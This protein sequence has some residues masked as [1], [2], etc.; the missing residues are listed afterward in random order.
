MN[1]LGKL[2][3]RN[4]Q[5]DDSILDLGSGIMQAT[6]ELNAKHI[7]GVDIF[8]N[9]LN[10]IKHKFLT[11]KLN[12]NETDR[13]MDDSYDIV[14]CLDVIE[15]LEKQLALHIISECKRICRKR[16]IIYTPHKFDDNKKAVPNSWGLGENPLQEHLCHIYLKDLESEG[17]SVSNPV[18]EGYLGVYIKNGN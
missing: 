1:W 14:L 3:Q 17:Y 8:D 7:L 9:Y 6:D 12:M 10:H 4:I 5:S 11:V 15:H 2:V 16:A 13:F 18:D